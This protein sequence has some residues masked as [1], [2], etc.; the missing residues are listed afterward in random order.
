MSDRRDL[1]SVMAAIGAAQHMAWSRIEP[2]CRMARKRAREARDI[3]VA[4]GTV[5][6][7]T[8]R[9]TDTMGRKRV[10]ELYS[11]DPATP[12]AVAMGAW[13]QAG[14][15]T[16]CP[17]P[18]REKRPRPALQ[19]PPGVHHDPVESTLEAILR[20]PGAPWRDVRPLCCCP[21]TVA[22]QARKEL[23]AGM[24]IDIRTAK[25][26]ASNGKVYYPYVYVPN[27]NHEL[28]RELR[29]RYGLKDPDP[30]VYHLYDPYGRYA[31]LNSS[32]PW[33]RE[34]HGVMAPEVVPGDALEVAGMILDPHGASGLK[35][36]AMPRNVVSVPIEVRQFE[37]VEA[38]ILEEY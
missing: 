2:L 27:E 37:D 38:E 32:E 16:P 31:S 29:K 13:F 6:V 4:E 8:D 36:I 17:L 19:R 18:D 12:I 7:T 28:V 3:L 23:A 34:L 26:T 30:S 1:L 10:R 11:I 24:V 20:N 9:Y 33:A 5:T 22:D 14:C 21:G 15:V 35:S 25:R